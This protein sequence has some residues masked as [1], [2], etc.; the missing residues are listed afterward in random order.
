MAIKTYKKGSSEKLSENFQAREFDCHGSGCCSKTLVD[1][2]LV[3]ALQKIR[4]HFNAKITVNS[5]FRCA[6]HNKNVSGA[7]NSM[8]TKGMAADIVVEGVAPAKVAAYAESIGILGIGLYET[9]GDG[10]FVHIDTR[11]TKSFWYG[12][13]QQKRATFCAGGYDLT[14]RNLSRGSTGADV[15]AVQTLLGCTADGI[16]GSKTEAAV[17]AY[18][19]AGGATADGIVGQMTMARLL[20]VEENE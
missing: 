16:F 13:A 17:K 6:V 20:G 10:Y 9:D 2:A 15:K 7:S 1:E 12:K 8:H 3:A 4:D 11:K 14:F 5:G 18:Q 19:K